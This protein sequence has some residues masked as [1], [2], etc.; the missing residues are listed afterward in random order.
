MQTPVTVPRNV[1]ISASQVAAVRVERRHNAV[2]RLS[3]WLNAWI[4]LG[5]MV[6]GATIYWASPVYQHAPDAATG[7]TDWVADAGVWLCAH[8]FRK[9][10]DPPNWF[11]NHFSFGPA[12]LADGLAVHWSLIYLF[13]LNGVVYVS[14]LLWDGSFRALLPRR[15]AID[16]ALAMFWYY[17]SWLPKV[18][19]RK[20]R[21]EPAG[22]SK[23]NA[24]QRFSYAGVTVI[25][26]LLVLSGW[27]IHKPTQ[28]H[29]L[30]RAFGGFQGA[31]EWHLWLMLAMIAFI[32]VHVALVTL[33]GFNTFRG[34][35]T[36]WRVTP[37][38]PQV[39]RNA[40]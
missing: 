16:D 18:L 14:A 5:L 34:M 36:G 2:V 19:L 28:F 9:Y 31:R 17:I 25:G 26:L 30:T 27:A 35:V 7:N 22:T 13:L 1:G 33:E 12:H 8:V 3:H 11:Y 38:V 24:L 4:L 37:A 32:V 40:E 23:Y 10:P 29:W 15:G 20:E 21:H 39:K 6:S